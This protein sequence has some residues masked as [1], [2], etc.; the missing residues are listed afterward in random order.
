MPKAKKRG[1][2]AKGDKE[3][4]LL[5]LQGILKLDKSFVTEQHEGAETVK[6]QVPGTENPVEIKL[7]PGQSE[8]DLVAYKAGY[9]VGPSNP[10]PQN[11]PEKEL[12]EQQKKVDAV[13]QGFENLKKQSEEERKQ[14]EEQF[15]RA[16]LLPD[17]PP[18]DPSNEATT[19]FDP[20]AANPDNPKNYHLP[21]NLSSEPAFHNDTPLE[22]GVKT[23]P[24]PVMKMNTED[25]STN[26]DRK[27][28]ISIRNIGNNSCESNPNEKES[29][30]LQ[31]NGEEY[32]HNSL[33]QLSS[34]EEVPVKDAHLLPSM[35]P[36]PDEAQ[37]GKDMVLDVALKMEEVRRQKRMERKK[38]VKEAEE[39]G[40][41][42]DPDDLEKDWES[43]DDDMIYSLDEIQELKK[44]EEEQNRNQAQGPEISETHM[45]Q[46]RPI[47][48]LVISR[49]IKHYQ[50]Q[51]LLY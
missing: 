43:Q 13:N 6:V 17:H 29:Q 48:C 37:F 31:S 45:Q 20:D 5:T 42:P 11:E 39:A 51:I 18:G 47:Y 7:V 22:F 19:P 23:V 32:E 40:L 9:A 34:N 28:D 14:R 1:R 25:K 33:S 10:L 15:K 50:T 4:P 36:L 2:G 12:F 44:K 35:K 24:L 21:D 30:A 27:G 8:H 16:G 46:V 3:K 49:L 26:G 41:A 38:R